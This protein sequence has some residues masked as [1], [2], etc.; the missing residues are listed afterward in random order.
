MKHMDQNTRYAI[1]KGLEEHLSI[2]EIAKELGIAG[3]TVSREIRHHLTVRRTGGQGHP[4]NDCRKRFGCE[5]RGICEGCL[6]DAK[7]QFCN[8]LCVTRCRSY[9]KQN[10]ERLEK[11]PYV[12]NGCTKRPVCTM[13][14]RLYDPA[15]AQKEYKAV[16]S[17]SHTGLTYTEEE[18]R[19]I[20]RIVSPL[21][22]K[23]Q[24]PAHI[25]K[26][27]ADELMISESTLYRLLD[28]GLLRARNVDLPR[29]VRFRARKKPRTLKVDKLCRVGRTY[30]DF[31]AYLEAH[32]GTAVVQGD[33]VEGVKGGKVLLTIHFVKTELMLAYIRDHNDSASVIERFGYLREKL[34]LENFQKI[35]PVLL[36]DNGS[37][38]S[39]PNMIEYDFDA[40]KHCT[41]VFYCDP[42]Q[43]QQKGSAERNHEFIR[44]IIPKGR[45][46]DHLC[47]KDISLMMD[48]INSYRRESLGWKSPYEAFEFFYGKDI[49]DRLG[50]KKIRPDDVD[51]TTELLKGK[52]PGDESDR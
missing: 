41:R 52:V 18:I 6:K 8:L 10:C 49:L 32:P 29:K 35:F 7:C 23:G 24:S 20:D 4:F 43:S 26:N 27:H 25:L 15:F 42:Q 38:F 13:E 12:C 11:P 33:S 2:T 5:L 48:H 9:E 21:L 44:Q 37:E 28:D 30:A 17:E 50:L 45:S 51:L 34:G 3:S 1:K 31:N 14:K 19:R 47:Q 40:G 39:N 46:M 16:W 22:M 36:L